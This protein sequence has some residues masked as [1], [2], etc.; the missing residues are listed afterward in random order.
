MHPAF[1][2]DW[3]AND[4][5][6]PTALLPSATEI[7]DAS[8]KEAVLKTKNGVVVPFKEM[9]H[10]WMTAKAQLH[11]PVKSAGYYQ[12]YDEALKWFRKYL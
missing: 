4:I 11:D 8:E 6:I 12:G 5:T 9:H 2:Q 3:D 1:L 7:K 10:G